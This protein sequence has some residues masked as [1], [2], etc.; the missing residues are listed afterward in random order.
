MMS[1]CA[2]TL[3]HHGFVTSHGIKKTLLDSFVVSVSLI[4]G[5]P[6]PEFL[7][8]KSGS[9]YQLTEFRQQLK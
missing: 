1:R 5:L 7:Y 4:S 3:Q 9:T 8:I 2:A 6:G